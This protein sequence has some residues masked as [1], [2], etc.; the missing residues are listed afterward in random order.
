MRVGRIHY[1]RRSASDGVLIYLK[2]SMTGHEGHR[3]AAVQIGHPAFPHEP[4]G[5]QFYGEDQF[6]SYRHLG[7]EVAQAAFEAATR[8]PDVSTGESR[9]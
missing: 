7:Q 8:G 5:N 3:D 1:A 9:S 6:E 4:T 2:A